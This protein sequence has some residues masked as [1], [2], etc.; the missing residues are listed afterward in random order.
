MMKLHA[1]GKKY[2]R[3]NQNCNHIAYKRASQAISPHRK[4]GFNIIFFP[5]EIQKRQLVSNKASF[6][7]SWVLVL[8]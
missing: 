5:F 2:V 8:C 4:M 1:D 6:F 3:Y 7:F